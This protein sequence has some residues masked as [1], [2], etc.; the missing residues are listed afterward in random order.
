ML[1][2]NEQQTLDP[3]DPGAERESILTGL[4]SRLE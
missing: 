2:Y 1:D 3:K 4:L